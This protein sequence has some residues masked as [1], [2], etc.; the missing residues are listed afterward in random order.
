MRKSD[1][2]KKILNN[3]NALLTFSVLFLV[4]WNMIALTDHFSV[5]TAQSRLFSFAENTSP[6]KISTVV[7]GHLHLTVK[8]QSKTNPT[9]V[10]HWHNME[11]DTISNQ[12]RNRS[13]CE[14]KMMLEG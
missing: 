7:F 3:K 14:Q 11:L 9:N 8:R 13:K 4:V 6:K 2:T 12:R 5:G 10:L 1:S